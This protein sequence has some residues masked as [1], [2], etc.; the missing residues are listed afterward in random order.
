MLLDYDHIILVLLLLLF[1]IVPLLAYVL[2]QVPVKLL[3]G[4]RLWTSIAFG[5]LVFV[6][7]F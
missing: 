3:I 1:I 4:T 5:R 2:I 7:E 6:D